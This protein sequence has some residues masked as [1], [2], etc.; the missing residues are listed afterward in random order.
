ML[1]RAEGVHYLEVLAA[2]HEALEPKLYL[3]IGTQKGRSLRP[4]R[5]RAIS[6]DPEFKLEPGVIGNQAEVNFVQDTSDAFFEQGAAERLLSE[7][8][9]FAFL[10]GM[11]LFEYLLRDFINT[12]RY[13]APD[14]T[15]MLHDCLPFSANMAARDRAK[16]QT[17]AWTGDVWKVVEILDRYRPDLEVTILDAAPTGLVA[18]RGMD[19]ANTVLSDNYDE[20]IAAYMDVEIVEDTPPDCMALDRWV[21]AHSYAPVDKLAQARRR[22]PNRRAPVA[23]KS[24]VPRPR[25][26]E[27]WGD[28]H[29]AVGLQSA[30]RRMGHECRIDTRKT[31]HMTQKIG[32]VEIAIRGIAHY[33]PKPGTPAVA[34][35][36]SHTS[37]VQPEETAEFTQ[38]FVAGSPGADRL[39]A[40]LLPQ[41]FDVDRMYPPE[42]PHAP[43]AGVFFAGIA[44]R[45][46]RPAVQFAVETNQPL[47]LWGQGWETGP[48]AKFFKGERVPNAQLGDYYRSAEVVL[49]DHT[50][51]MAAEGI[52]SNRIFDALACGTP[53]VSDALAW[54]PEDMKPWVYQFEDRESF[55]K[56]IDEARN[57][58]P[59]KRA[60]RHEFALS[61]RQTHSFDARA[62][63]LMA[64]LNPPVTADMIQESA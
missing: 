60:A 61:M 37:K 1:Y 29:F 48:A 44:R 36:I 51:D 52:P 15:V 43:R 10:D 4:C 49:N 40:T 34:W 22:D 21:E 58:T 47:S 16:V 26:A 19:P 59:E 31:W 39:D 46:P 28:H 35:V 20:I 42:D 3:E 11:H 9:D 62:K 14:A 41:A 57:E 24:P 8:V 6:V 56:A 27:R 25:V 30:L 63:T 64:A 12:E 7:P 38:A 17:Q 13:V 32:E 54:L 18:V 45:F 2:L 50:P 55:A 5:C 53:V 33:K 23:I